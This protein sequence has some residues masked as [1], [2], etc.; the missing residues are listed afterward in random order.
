MGAAILWR[1]AL[2]LLTV[3]AVGAGVA[4]SELP[5]RIPIHFSF[6]GTSDAWADTS[7]LTWFGP[8]GI[9]GALFALL[10]GV[11][12]RRPPSLPEPAGP[13]HT[14]EQRGEPHASSAERARLVGAV[15]AVC[16]ACTFLALQ[17]GIFLVAQGITR[18]SPWYI[19]LAIWAPIGLMVLF[20]IGA[21]RPGQR[22]VG[23]PPSAG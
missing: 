4:W 22:T 10:Y 12:A 9:A 2:A 14:M 15:C 13:E 20:S 1:V 19:E 16:I 8:L 17:A 7:A 6:G 21:S 11:T 23:Q 3:H 5:D 18:A